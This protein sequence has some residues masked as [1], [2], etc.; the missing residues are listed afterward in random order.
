MEKNR[1]NNSSVLKKLIGKPSSWIFPF[2][3]LQTAYDSA[4]ESI[5]FFPKFI[6]RLVKGVFSAHGE[7]RRIRIRLGGFVWPGPLGFFFCGMSIFYAATGYWLYS[8][9]FLVALIA[10]CFL[11]IDPDGR[12]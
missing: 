10:L 4:I 12:S 1:E 5:V 3:A 9:V 6:V 11:R 7:N 8:V 2:H